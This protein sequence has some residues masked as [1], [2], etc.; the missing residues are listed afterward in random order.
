MSFRNACAIQL[1]VGVPAK[2]GPL[3]VARVARPEFTK[4]TLTRADPTGSPSRLHDTAV[5]AA[6]PMAVRAAAGSNAGPSTGLSSEPVASAGSEPGRS[7]TE[8]P[9][10]DALG[11]SFVVAAPTAASRGLTTGLGVAVAA[12]AETVGIAAELDVVTEPGVAV[13]D[14]S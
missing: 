6:A 5:A 2:G 7:A 3:T 8:G 10:A 11:A 12:T 4:V 14:G 13:V 9:E 1:P